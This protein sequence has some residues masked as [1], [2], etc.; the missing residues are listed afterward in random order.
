MVLLRWAAGSTLQAHIVTLKM[1]LCRS[2]VGEGQ[3]GGV[4]QLAQISAEF[5]ESEPCLRSQ[6]AWPRVWADAGWFVSI[7]RVFLTPEGS[8]ANKPSSQVPRNQQGPSR[9]PVQR[10]QSGISKASLI[11]PTPSIEADDEDS[12]LE[13]SR[14]NM[15]R[16]ARAPG[17]HEPRYEDED[18]R[19]TSRKELAGWYSYGWAA[20]VFAICAM[21]KAP[22][23]SQTCTSC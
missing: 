12:S 23:L 8:A 1:A 14:L 10:S 19:P 17:S 18:S 4:G 15:E 21:G 5:P 9:P 2:L 13:D 6:S 16:E 7:I 11:S 20:E 3:D 22:E